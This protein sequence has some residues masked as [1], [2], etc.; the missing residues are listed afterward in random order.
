VFPPRA[1]IPGLND[2]KRLSPVARARLVPA[3]RATALAVGV[4]LATPEEIDRIN[5]LQAS[6]LSMVRAVQALPLAPDCLLVDGVHS[7]PLPIPQQT[8]IRG[9]ALSTSVAAASVLAKQHRDALMVD[10]A[11]AYPDY[12]FERNKGYPTRAHREALVRLGPC[13]IHRASFNGVRKRRPSSLQP[14]LLPAWERA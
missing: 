4:G 3:I 10:Y 7:V 5:I 14:D 2:S 1:D 12:G 8:L 13:P 9:D 6:L 11:A